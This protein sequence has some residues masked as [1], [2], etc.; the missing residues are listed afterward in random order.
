M[1]VKTIKEFKDLTIDKIRR[2]NYE[3]FEV[4]KERANLLIKMGF[5]EPIIQTS[6]QKVRN[7]KEKAR[8]TLQ[9]NKL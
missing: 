9:V 3:P 1:K 2:L 5:V 4:E 7:K 6:I 8:K